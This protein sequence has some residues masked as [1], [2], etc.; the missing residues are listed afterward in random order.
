MLGTLVIAETKAKEGLILI[1]FAGSLIASLS[2]IAA[3]QSEGWHRQ[4]TRV[5]AIV[6][7]GRWGGGGGREGG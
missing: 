1:A 2:S 3:M 5:T 7:G 4:C 6:V